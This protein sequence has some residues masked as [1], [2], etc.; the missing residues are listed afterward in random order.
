VS[1][2]KANELGSEGWELAGVGSFSSGSIIMEEYIF[3][4]AK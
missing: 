1:Q 4:R 2:K 3:K